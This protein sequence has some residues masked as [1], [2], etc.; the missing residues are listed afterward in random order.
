MQILMYIFVILMSIISIIC[1]LY[2][3]FSMPVIFIWK[4]YRK[5]K[6]GKSLYD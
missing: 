2:L 3:T 1:C 6:Y 5:I 4:V